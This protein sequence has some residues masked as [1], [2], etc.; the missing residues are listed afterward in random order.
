MA[1]AILPEGAE[2]T[3]L[4]AERAVAAGAVDAWDEAAQLARAKVPVHVAAG[5]RGQRRI[6]DDIA[7]R[8]RAAPLAPVGEDRRDGAGCRLIL[9]EALGSLEGRPA[10]VGAARPARR[11]VVHLL[12]R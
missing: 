5:K 11:R 2:A 9:V 3:H 4:D 8:D 1:R 6:A 7:A 10:E 12:E